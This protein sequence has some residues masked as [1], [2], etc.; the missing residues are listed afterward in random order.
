MNLPERL[1][2]REIKRKEIIDFVLTHPDVNTLKP[3]QKALRLDVRTYFNPPNNN[4]IKTIRKKF[5]NGNSP[6][7]KDLEQEHPYTQSVQS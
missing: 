4:L 3:I 7:Y 5:S 6:L 2:A 1:K